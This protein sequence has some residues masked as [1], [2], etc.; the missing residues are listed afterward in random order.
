[1]FYPMMEQADRR[2]RHQMSNATAGFAHDGL[3]E[4]FDGLPPVTLREHPGR[5]TR[6]SVAVL[7]RPDVAALEVR[8]Y[9]NGRLESARDVMQAAANAISAVSRFCV[10]VGGSIP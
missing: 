3:I 9:E 8:R 4:L 6:T 2:R 1:M 10:P 7:I 5:V